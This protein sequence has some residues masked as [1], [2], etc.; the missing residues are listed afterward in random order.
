M[1]GARNNEF[2]KRAIEL[3]AITSTHCN[4]RCPGCPEGRKEP[5]RGGLMSMDMFE[6]ILA[7]WHNSAE[8]K[9]MLA[10]L[11]FLERAV[12]DSP[13]AADG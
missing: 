6:R 5:L 12:P 10:Q 11:D 7:K 4:L 2:M 13:H 3:V 8:C 1:R 9:V